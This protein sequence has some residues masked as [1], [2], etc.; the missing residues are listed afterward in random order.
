L[1]N[2][3]AAGSR[4]IG[5]ARGRRRNPYGSIY[6]SHTRTA[7]LIIQHNHGT[8]RLGLRRRPP[9][10]YFIIFSFPR[11]TNAVVP[12]ALQH[13]QNRVTTSEACSTAHG[14]ESRQSSAPRR[15]PRCRCTGRAFGD[16][17][18]LRRTCPQHTFATHACE[19]IK[20]QGAR[21]HTAETGPASRAAP[22]IFAVVGFAARAIQHHAP[23]VLLVGRPAHQ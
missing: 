8:I 14:S 18:T 23:A 12:R 17:P 20:T 16:A 7:E 10:H 15:W 4:I 1:T 6:S 13:L 2:K 5:R 21:A 22:R 11:L 9:L 3:C 19:Q